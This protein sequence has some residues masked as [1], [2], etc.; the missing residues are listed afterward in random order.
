MKKAMVL[1]AAAMLLL[2]PVL[3]RADTESYWLAKHRASVDLA[4]KKALAFLATRQKPDG[5]FE[6]SW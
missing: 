1:T 6:A 3:A 4:V 5:S 2:L